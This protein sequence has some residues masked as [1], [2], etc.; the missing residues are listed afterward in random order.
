MIF[1]Y[2]IE[3][4]T[5]VTLLGANLIL[6]VLALGHQIAKNDSKISFSNIIWA[7]VLFSL[8]LIGITLYGSVLLM[9]YLSKGTKEVKES[10]SVA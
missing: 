10:N 3:T 4:S 6:S 8:P 7:I 1:A 5:L 9:S 2:M